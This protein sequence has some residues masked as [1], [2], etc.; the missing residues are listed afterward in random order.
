MTLSRS[1]PLT[2]KRKPR[3]T[4]SPRCHIQRCGK[5]ATIA[6]LCVTHA[7]RESW[8]LF[9][10]FIRNRDGRCTAAGLFGFACNGP[11]Q[12][13]HIIGRRNWQVRLDP[14][15]VHAACA[16]HHRWLDS[17]GREGYK[18]EWATR[19]LGEAE[20]D[21]LYA[22]ALVMGDRTQ[23]IAAALAIL[24]AKEDA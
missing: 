16:A 19:I 6:G 15:N 3:R 7:D 2:K 11:L 21:R 14:R 23:A 5:R 22:D 9:S 10:L 1:K 8:R 13:A 12:A 17:S 4:T 24:T 20:Y 18:R